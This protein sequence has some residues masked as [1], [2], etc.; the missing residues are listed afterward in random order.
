MTPRAW[1]GVLM[2]VGC[3]EPR[4][5]QAVQTPAPV[6]V[7]ESTPEPEPAPP[8]RE[9]ETAPAPIPPAQPT[10]TRAGA[11]TVVTIPETPEDILAVPGG[12]VWTQSGEVWAAFDDA[13]A[14]TKLSALVDPH[15]LATDGVTVWWL[16]DTENGRWDLKV[17]THATWRTFGRAGEQAAV[18]YGDAV[19]G[20]GTGALWRFEGQ[21]ARRIPFRFDAQWRALAGLGAGHDRVVFPVLARLPDRI[22]KLYVRVRGSG[23]SATFETRVRPKPGRWAVN[24]AGDLAFLRKGE[25]ALVRASAKT[26]KVALSDPDVRLL[27]WCGDRLCTVAHGVLRRHVKKEVE[28]V[29]EVGEAERLSCGTDRFAWLVTQ[30]EER[31]ELSTQL[32]PAG[33]H[34]PARGPSRAGSKG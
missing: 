21:S 13:D 1:V 33:D 26:P 28:P 10:M 14:P 20:R 34:V 29:A 5:P 27:C 31:S 15:G 2:V 16:G 8:T 7:P 12:V 6:R 17:R 22:A 18:A 23:K 3:A 4:P 19:Y 32:W 11:R 9:P 24:R 30:A 25:V